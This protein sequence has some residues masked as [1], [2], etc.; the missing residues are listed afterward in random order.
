MSGFFHG[1]H[2]EWYHN[3]FKVFVILFDSVFITDDQKPKRQDSWDHTHHVLTM[4]LT[5]TFTLTFDLDLNLDP[6]LK[7]RYM[8]TKLCLRQ[9]QPWSNSIARQDIVACHAHPALVK[10]CPALVPLFIFDSLLTP[11]HVLDYES[12]STAGWR[13]PA[14]RPGLVHL[15]RE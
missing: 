5:L 9:F 1:R 7:A 6:E 14:C 8:T 2:N 13:L 4:A 15:F 12:V 10:I 11:M 3:Y